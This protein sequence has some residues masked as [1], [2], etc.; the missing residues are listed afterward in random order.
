M[1]N[2][3]AVKLRNFENHILNLSRGEAKWGITIC[4]AGDIRFLPGFD[5]T[6]SVI[7]G[8]SF[9][10]NFL[11]LVFAFQHAFQSYFG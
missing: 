4:F 11:T 2:E 3:Q 7:L 5:F 10:A 8:E 6:L 9:A 1:K